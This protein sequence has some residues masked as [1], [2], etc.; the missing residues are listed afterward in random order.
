MA[1]HGFHRPGTRGHRQSGSDDVV[2]RYRVSVET[3]KVRFL[4]DITEEDS[5]TVESEMSDCSRW[6]RG[7]DSPA[8]D[9]TP[10]PRPAEV[11]ERIDTLEEWVK[12]IRRRRS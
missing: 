8:A 11:K 7:H 2:E 3:Q 9:G 1:A 4:H 12:S 5:K 6:M 10:Y